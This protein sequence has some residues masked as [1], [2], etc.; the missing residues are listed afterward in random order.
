MKLPKLLGFVVGLLFSISAIAEPLNILVGDLTFTRPTN[1]KWEPPDPNSP[2]VSRFVVPNS[3]GRPG[4][5]RFYRAGV[6]PEM[7]VKQWHKYA[8]AEDANSLRQE[9]KTVGNR[10]ITYVFLKGTLTLPG[11]RPVS[12]QGFVGVVI[13]FEQKFLHLRFSGPQDIIDNAIAHLKTMV[14]DAVKE[15]EAEL[16]EK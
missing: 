9:T 6:E 10:T 8:A 11:E 3:S 4:E 12:N 2:A 15:R 5:L 13:P 7:A 1:W 16:S 14:E